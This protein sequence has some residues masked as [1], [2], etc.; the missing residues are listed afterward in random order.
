MRSE[1]GVIRKGVRALSP[2]LMPCMATWAARRMSS[3][4]EL[5]QEPMSAALIVA[6]QPFVLTSAASFDTGRSRS[7]ECGPTM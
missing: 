2:A 5:V 7:G 1:P 3:Y 4:E 6:G